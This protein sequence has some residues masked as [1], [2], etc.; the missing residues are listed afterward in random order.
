MIFR[1]IFD[2]IFHRHRLWRFSSFSEIAE[3]YA[4][5]M[6]RTVA[7]Y[8]GASF[9]SVYMFKMGYSIAF[10]SLFWAAH[11]GVKVLLMLP[12]AQMIANIGSKKALVLSNFL[13]IPSM[14]LLIWLPQLGLIALAISG[15]LQSI[16]SALYQM[17]YTVAFSRVNNPEKVGRQVAA[18]NIA[19]KVAKGVSPLIGGLLAMFFDPR[20]AI[21]A[22]AFFY[23]LA[24]WPMLRTKDTMSTGFKLF[25]K[26]FP[27]RKAYRSLVAQVPVG[28]DI[29]ASGTAWS[30]FLVSLIFTASNN[31]VYAEVGALTSLI[32]GVSLI[33]TYAYGK[34]ID[35]RAGGQ[36]LMWTAIGNVVTDIFRALVRTPVMA[37][38]NNATKE[39][40]MTGYS[41]AF[42]RGMLD[43]ADR[44]GYRVLYVGLATMVMNIGSLAAALSLALSVLLFETVAGF[45]IFYLL[46]AAVAA[47]LALAKFRL[48]RRA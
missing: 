23:L 35:K 15:F 48:Y 4:V 41:M 10:I 6:I 44:S 32:L 38:S 36:L 9:L 37:V 5:R 2:N 43:E 17:G 34:L 30:I 18:M 22:S 31:K 16:S 8:V 7:Y 33:S 45:T 29:Y 42:M 1:R 27:W 39:F 26:K 21:L 40:V 46:A 12:L 24:V 47:T 14:L 19:E 20:A 25:P 13:Y 28:F 11:F 3:L